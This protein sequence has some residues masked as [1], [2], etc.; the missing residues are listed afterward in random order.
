MT[1]SGPLPCFHTSHM[2][3]SV[4]DRQRSVEFYRDLLGLEVVLQREKADDYT[5]RLIGYPGA[6]LLMAVLRLPGTSAYLE[7]IEH[8]DVPREPV[9]TGT[10]NPGT[11]HLCLHVDDLDAVYARLKEAGVASVSEVQLVTTGPLTGAK[12]VYMIDPDGIRVELLDS[13]P[14]DMTGAPLPSRPAGLAG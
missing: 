12:V 11:C 9:D 14:L 6:T 10:A 1:T 2:G 13:S 3:I 4:A 5:R 8:R 7:I